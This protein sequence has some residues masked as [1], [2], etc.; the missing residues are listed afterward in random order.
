MADVE[1]ITTS[2]VVTRAQARER[3]L[4]RYFTGL[5]CCRGHISERVT[6]NGCCRECQIN[7]RRSPE[8]KARDREYYNSNKERIYLVSKI[9]VA[10]N[11]DRHRELQKRSAERPSSK[12]TNRLASA[13]IRERNPHKSSEW[14]A[15]NRDRARV[16]AVVS[17]AKRKAAKINATPAWADHDKIRKVYEDRDRISKETGVEHNVDHIIPLIGKTVCGLHVHYNLRVIPYIE[18]MKKSNRLIESLAA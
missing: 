5:P 6:A 8:A 17:A 9:W 15:A 14:K 2:L 4:S 16:H 18:N 13:R 12:E 1:S 10:A 3:N 7:D 11:R